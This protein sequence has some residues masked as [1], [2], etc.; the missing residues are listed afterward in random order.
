MDRPKLAISLLGQGGI[1]TMSIDMI[2]NHFR[3]IEIEGIYDD[4]DLKIHTSFKNILI[5]DSIN[6]YVNSSS[7][8]SHFIVCIG[9]IKHFK[10]RIYYSN[11]LLKKG[12][13]SFTLIHPQSY[14][15][16]ETHLGEGNWIC[17]NVSIESNANLG[18]GNIIFNNSVIEHDSIIHNNCYLSPSVTVCGKVTISDN[19]Y[20]G[21]GA[22]IAAGVNIGKN[23]LIGAGSVVLRDVPENR[24]LWGNPAKFIKMNDLW[25]GL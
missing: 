18:R 23:V 11:L 8:G 6:N 1:C 19:V 13:K 5:K 12:A 21:P 25:G 7:S 9:N 16:K 24:V 14:I 10:A 3:Y 15:S 2:R 20:I 22:I 4:S 17:A